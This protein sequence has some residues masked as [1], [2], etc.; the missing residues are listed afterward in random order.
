MIFSRTL[1]MSPDDD[2]LLIS[3]SRLL[4]LS[5]S[6]FD[7]CLAI[8]AASPVTALTDLTPVKMKTNQNTE[9]TLECRS[10]A[11]IYLARVPGGW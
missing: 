6:S 1:F 7:L 8:I 3:V 2:W 5:S 9:E 11:I 4:T 10:E